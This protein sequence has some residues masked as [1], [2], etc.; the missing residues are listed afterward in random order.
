SRKAVLPSARS[1]S[2]QPTMDPRPSASGPRWV[3][4]KNCLPSRNAWATRSIIVMSPHPVPGVDLV[5]DRLRL[6]RRR[7]LRDLRQKALHP[8]ALLV[9]LVEHEPELRRHL[10]AQRLAHPP[11]QK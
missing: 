4:S 10:G 9:L 11:P 5:R 2:A 6:A 7:L 3:A 1:I 8:L